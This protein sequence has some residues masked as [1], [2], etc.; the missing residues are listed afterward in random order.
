M[1][2]TGSKNHSSNCGASN[3]APSLLMK[4]DEPVDASA[5]SSKE[6]ISEVLPLIPLKACRLQLARQMRIPSIYSLSFS[7]VL[8]R[9]L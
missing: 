6:F 3:I 1:C 4:L 7:F 2:V 8:C 5:F 9:I